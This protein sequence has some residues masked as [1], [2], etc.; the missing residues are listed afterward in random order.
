MIDLTIIETGNGGDAI[1]LGNDLAKATGMENQPYLAMFSGDGDWWGNGLLLANNK[2]LQY[3][4]E[5]EQALKSTALNSAGR[6]AIERAVM[7]DL[8]YL[9][10]IVPGTNVTVSARLTQA[11]RVDIEIKI[12][13]ETFAYQ[14]NPIDETLQ[15]IV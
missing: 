6:I 10:K 13:G 12:G 11:S 14:W 4:S 7:N 9:K 2:I 8:A 3:S 5:T 1:L 15:P